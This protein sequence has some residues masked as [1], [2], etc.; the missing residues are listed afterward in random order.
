MTTDPKVTPITLAVSDEQRAFLS[1]EGYTNE[2]IDAMAK[3][4]GDNGITQERWDHDV[5]EIIENKRKAAEREAA[6]RA[7]QEVAERKANRAA[8]AGLAMQGLLANPDVNFKAASQ[9]SKAAVAHADGLLKALDA[10]AAEG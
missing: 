9:Y 7:E 2:A 6:Y 1:G 3:E 5:A 8:F 10:P 4:N